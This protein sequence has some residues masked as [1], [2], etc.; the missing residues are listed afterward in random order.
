MR[1]R[2]RRSFGSRRGPLSG[3]LRRGPGAG[4]AGWGPAPL[5]APPAAAEGGD[6]AGQIDQIGG[7]RAHRSLP[8]VRPRG[9]G[10]A[11]GGAAIGP[12]GAPRGLRRRRRLPAPDAHL[13]GGAP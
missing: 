8:P 2:R 13:P 5:H 11:G 1:C 9:G 4:V 7:G 10:G 3:T 6:G 12:P